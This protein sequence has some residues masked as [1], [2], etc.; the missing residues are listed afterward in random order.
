MS[1]EE[2]ILVVEDD[3]HISELLEFNLLK[4]GYRVLTSDT[5]TEGLKMASERNPNLQ[6]FRFD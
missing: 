4:Q 5:G 1:L 6:I 3:R 2:V